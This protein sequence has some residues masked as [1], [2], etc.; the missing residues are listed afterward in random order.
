MDVPPC[1]DVC[2]ALDEHVRRFFAGRSVDAVTWHAGPIRGA[3]PHFR[4]LRV[5]PTAPG[6]LWQYVSVG[7]W[8][9]T[10]DRD[11]GLEF[12]LSSPVETDRAVELLAMTVYYHGD[13]RLGLG[14]TVP[15]GEPW[16]PGS[17]C[18]HL[19]VSL[20]YPFGP[21]LQ[22]CH[23]ADRHVDFLWLLPITKAEREFTM[24]HGLEELEQRFDAAGL[25]YW[26]PERASV[27]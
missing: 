25:R 16:L 2:A 1:D 27:V 8:A 6:R 23:T 20:P 12:V 15:I 11:A 3:N 9:A 4:V 17:A 10:A 24:E 13:E 22:L 14:H 18:D 21:D 19:L 7:G 5:A 26:E